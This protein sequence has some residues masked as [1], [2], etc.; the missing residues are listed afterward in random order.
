[1]ELDSDKDMVWLALQVTQHR[2]LVNFYPGTSIK[3]RTYQ[4]V[5]QFMPLMFRPDRD[6]K[7]CELEEVNGIDQ[8]DIFQARWFKPITSWAP[9]Q[10]CGHTIFSLFPPPGHKQNLG[11]WPLHLPQEDLCQKM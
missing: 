8:G 6:V 9:S 11:T 5:V 4:I 3:P 10:V 7:L 1:M 2:F